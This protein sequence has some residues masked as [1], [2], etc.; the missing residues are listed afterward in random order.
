MAGTLSDEVADA[1]DNAGVVILCL[2]E[3]YERCPNCQRG[4]TDMIERDNSVL[5]FVFGDVQFFCA[6]LFVPQKY[7]PSL[8]ILSPSQTP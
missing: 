8:K 6:S 3:Y 1:I 2:S 5:I 7:G 4:E